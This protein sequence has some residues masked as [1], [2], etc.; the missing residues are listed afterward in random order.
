MSTGTTVVIVVIAII[1]IGAVAAVV[2]F[3][4]RRRRLQQR[5]GPEYDRL[6][7]EHD[8]R[9]KAEAELARRERRVSKLDI[10]PLDPAIRA[11]YAQ[12]WAII[13]ERFVDGPQGAVTQAQHLVVAVMNDRGYRTD[14]EQQLLADLSVDHAA[15]VDHYRSATVISERTSAGTSST[16]DLRQAVIHYRALFQDLLGEPAGTERQAVS[17]DRE[18]MYTER[19]TVTAEPD[20]V[21]AE[22]ADAKPIDAKPID[23]KPIDAEP[24]DAEAAPEDAPDKPPPRSTASG[25]ASSAD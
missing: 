4:T 21:D 9:L 17:T 2:M 5:F 25:G 10:K 13:Q 18:A 1:V 22:R 16:E 14:D 3:A 12:E 15:F 23:A 8:S 6:V 24:I 19:D 20:A 7:K 11:S